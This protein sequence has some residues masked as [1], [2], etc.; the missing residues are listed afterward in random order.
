MKKQDINYVQ[1]LAEF[2]AYGVDS[3]YSESLND[4]TYLWVD[5]DGGCFVEDLIV[6]AAARLHEYQED[7]PCRENAVALTKLEEAI[8]WLESRKISRETRGVRGTRES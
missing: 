6:L 1:K 2:K 5:F 3:E 7:M 4:E 8:H